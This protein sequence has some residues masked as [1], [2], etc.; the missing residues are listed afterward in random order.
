MPIYKVK[1][2]GFFGGKVYDPEGK[3]RT[4]STDKPFPAKKF[5]QWLE[6]LKEETAAQKKKRESAERKA[7]ADA[8]KKAKQD[9]ED[10]AQATF[11]GEGETAS[12]PS[13]VVETL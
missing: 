11:M 3:R 4:L 8:E 7:A 12:G 2:R 10:I 1:S 5:P 6:P 13:D 9:K